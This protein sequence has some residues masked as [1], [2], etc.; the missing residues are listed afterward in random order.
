MP[1]YFDEG[2]KKSGAC[3]QRFESYRKAK[4]IRE[5]KELNPGPTQAG[6][7]KYDFHHG[8]LRLLPGSALSS[9][10]TSLRNAVIAGSIVFEASPAGKGKR[11]LPPTPM[12]MK[13]FLSSVACVPTVSMML[14]Q[15]IPNT[16]P[17][18]VL[19]AHLHDLLAT[20]AHLS[21][22]QATSLIAVFGTGVTRI[23]QTIPA[24]QHPWITHGL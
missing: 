23:F 1:R 8:F 6:D 4:S 9:L 3:G 10:P 15:T 13:T 12:S 24:F 5:Y 19:S 20:D 18:G 21:M 16:I 14:L 2:H 7:A 17:W 11:A 22:P